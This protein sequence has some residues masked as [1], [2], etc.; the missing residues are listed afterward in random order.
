MFTQKVNLKIIVRYKVKDG[1]SVLG[2]HFLYKDLP[3]ETL[4]RHS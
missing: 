2:S 4:I 1:I 3:L